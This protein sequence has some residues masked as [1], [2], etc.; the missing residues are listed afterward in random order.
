M[1]T[2]DLDEQ[3]QI[4]ELKTW[5]KMH[6]NLVTAVVVAVSLA[7]V[8]WQ[9]WNWWQR[10]QSAD[11]SVIYSA[12][13]QAVVAKDA[14]RARD[15]AGELIDKYSATA[16]AG[17]AAMLS[18][19]VQTDGGDPKTARAQL[20]WAA[21]NAKDDA[22]RDLARLRLA[23][24]LLDDKSYDDALKQL[25]AEPAPSFAPRF[26]ELK[27]DVFAAQ[28]KRVEAKAAYESALAKLDAVAKDDN[29][30]HG[31]YR[32]ILQAKVESMGNGK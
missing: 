22:L 31:A 18:A 21:D 14:K 11:A 9:G 25:A 23:A 7:V 19:K 6:G 17:M 8:G 26:A 15:L 10:K 28:G 2:F 30:R 4:D 1:A 5:W 13:Q 12:M 20:A 27:G 32:D 24:T 3:E 29:A 16:Y